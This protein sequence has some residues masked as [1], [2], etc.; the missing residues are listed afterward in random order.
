MSENSRGAMLRA[1]ARPAPPSMQPAKPPAD[2]TQRLAALL[3][4]D[5][6]DSAPEAEFDALVRAASLACGAPISLIS[7]IDSQRQWFKANIGLPG[8]TET[9]RDL[10]FCAHA[11][12]DDAL[13]EV[14]D[15][16]LDPRFADKPLVSG[17]P[18]IRF[19][20]GAPVRLSDGHRVGTLCVIDT[21]PRQL[22]PQQREILRCLAQV[23]AQAL[24]NRRNKPTPA[25]T[26]T[27]PRHP[28]P[29]A[30]RGHPGHAAFHRWPG[31]PAGRQ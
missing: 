19:D 31:L 8:I 11:V 25:A 17:Q 16:R 18:D 10:A 7:L 5:V 6:L 22:Q 20:A 4:L 26:H 15:A 9:P 30:V 29:S 1:G 12:L 13:F 21:Q 3:S 24:E 23:A 28:G 14:A 27:A 2:E